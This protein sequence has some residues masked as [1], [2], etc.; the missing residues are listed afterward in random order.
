MEYLTRTTVGT[1]AY[2]TLE[3]P[4][5]KTLPRDNVVIWLPH[6]R[7]CIIHGADKCEKNLNYLENLKRWCEIAPGRVYIWDYGVNYGEN[8]LYPFP[9]IRSMGCSEIYINWLSLSKARS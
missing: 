4:P 5:G 9:V 1:F 7:H 6:L 3:G 2:M 8:F